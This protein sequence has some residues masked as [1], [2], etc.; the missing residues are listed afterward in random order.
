VPG[1]TQIVAPPSCL[2]D[3]TPEDVFTMMLVPSQKL[4]PPNSSPRLLSRVNDQPVLRTSTSISPDC[5][6]VKRFCAVT[7]THLTLPAS[8]STAAAIALQ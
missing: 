1:S 6:A 2:T 7:D 8:P 4:I 3:F 5:S